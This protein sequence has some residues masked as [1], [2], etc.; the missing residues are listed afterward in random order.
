MTQSRCSPSSTRTIRL[1][2]PHAR[3]Q[4]RAAPKADESC[5]TSPISGL[6]PT[7]R[8]WWAQLRAHAARRCRT[9]SLRASRRR[10]SAHRR[11]SYREPRHPDS[12]QVTA[13]ARRS[14]RPWSRMRLDL[15]QTV[16]FAGLILFLGY[17][18]KRLIP[19]LALQ[20][21]SAGG[22]RPAGGGALRRRQRDGLAS[23]TFDTRCRRRCRTRSSPRSDSAP[24]SCC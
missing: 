11:S 10:A 8:N 5:A 23:A 12:S 2:G 20:H 4:G 18:L 15:I 16:A 1:A 6:R 22:R 9:G 13:R 24:A 19:A 17:G 7:S 21:S 3:I 14:T